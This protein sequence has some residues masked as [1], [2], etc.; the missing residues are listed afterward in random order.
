[1]PTSDQIIDHLESIS[2]ARNLE[3]EELKALIESQKKFAGMIHEVSRFN[4]LPDW[5]INGTKRDAMLYALMKSYSECDPAEKRSFLTAVKN[6]PN[7]DAD[8]MAT[9]IDMGSRKILDSDDGINS[10]LSKGAVGMIMPD[11]SAGEILGFSAGAGFIGGMLG[12]LAC[13]SLDTAFPDS[14]LADLILGKYHYNRS[15]ALAR[16]PVLLAIGITVLAVVVTTLST[17]VASLAE[18]KHNEIGACLKGLEALDTNTIAKLPWDHNPELYQNFMRNYENILE[19]QTMADEREGANVST[20]AE[21]QQKLAELEKQLSGHETTLEF[22][23]TL[24]PTDDSDVALRGKLETLDASNIMSQLTHGGITTTSV[25]A[26]KRVTEAAD[27]LRS[28]LRITGDGQAERLEDR[29][30]QN[31]N[32]LEM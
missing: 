1:M 7:V 21:N 29:P 28:R 3:I 26:P 4:F 12:F 17:A 32:R 20:L 15:E 9:A 8:R 10:L 13:L 23:R 2:G 24:L 16:N 14:P 25:S 5:V 30:K 19:V 27:E 22:I 31:P 11:F 6:S 18:K